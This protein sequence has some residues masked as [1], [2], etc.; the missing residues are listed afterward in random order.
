MRIK[1]EIKFLH[2]KKQQLNHQIYYLHLTLANTWNN[3]WQY[4]LHTIESKLQKEVQKKYQN[5]D[6]K[7]KKLI[8]SQTIHP[9][10]KHKFYPRVINNT[11]ILFTKCE[12]TLLQK[13]LKYNL[14]TKQENWIQD[15]ALEAETAIQTLPTSDHDM[16]YRHMVVD[17]I[18]TLQKNSNTQSNPNSAKHEAKT[19]RSIQSK[20]RNNDA[21]IICA[22]K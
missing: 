1:D 3:T 12:M 4:M 11:D 6:K 18:N 16:M 2:A 15:L 8:Q 7:L 9:Q 21:T 17:R 14:H 20:L 13:G 22:D 19:R 10:Q 5:L